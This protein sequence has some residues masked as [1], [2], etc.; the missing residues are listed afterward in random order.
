ML[1]RG[2]TGGVVNPG[3]L[4]VIGGSGWPA[5]VAARLCGVVAA[6]RVSL[7]FVRFCEMG[8]QGSSD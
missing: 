7:N 2:V 6:L 4:G 3:G 1:S 5:C 8:F